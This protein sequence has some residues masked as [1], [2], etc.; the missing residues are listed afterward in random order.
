MQKI[1]VILQWI[2][3]FII[4]AEA[5]IVFLRMK[6]RT[7]YYL[8][9]NCV[10][11]LIHA[12]GYLLRLGA[13]SEE[14]YFQA[15]L[16]EW[17]GRIW[18]MVSLLMFFFRFCE[19]RPP[20]TLSS[21]LGL[22]AVA[23]YSIIITTE[24]TGLFYSGI[25]F[26]K[27]DNGYA[28]Q[29]VRG[30]WYILW[31]IMLILVFSLS[32]AMLFGSL[33]KEKN[34]IRKKQVILVINA[35][36]VLLVLSL[37][38]IVPLR[39]NEYIDLSQFAFS[40]SAIVILIAIVRYSL[41]ETREL[42]REY[43]IDELADG[44]IALD[45]NGEVVYYNHAA[46]LIFPE[47]KEKEKEIVAELKN[48]LETKEPL[49]IDDK[50][51]E[52][53]EKYL[54]KAEV[55]M[56][57]IYS[58][59]DSTEFYQHMSQLEEQKEL[60]DLANQAKSEFL[61]KMSHE[62]R[63]PI[64]AVLGMDEMIL[65]ETND[66]QVRNYA[67]D[68]RTAGRTPLTIINDILDFSKIET[69]KIEIDPEEYDVSSMIYD[70]SNMT[71]VRAKA[72]HL[73]F[74]LSV[75]P[76]VPSKLFGDDVRIRQVLTNILSNAVKY[77]KEG[78]IDF[79]VLL[80]QGPDDDD[81][82]VLTFE[83]EDTGI[84][85]K[86]EDI[87]KLFIEFERI[88][89]IKNT[90]VQGTGLG[91]AITSRMLT[92]MDTNLQIKSEYGKG[93]VFSFD[94]TQK[95][96]D[97]SPIGDFDERIR[98]HLKLGTQYVSS[99]KAPDAR[100]LVVDDNGINL[101]VFASLLKETKIR[102]TEAMSGP[103]AVDLARTLHFDLI[104]MD[105]MMPG[106][107]GI[108]AM[109][110]IRK[111]KDGP[112]ADTPI[113]VLTANA[114]VGSKEMYLKEGFDNFISKPIVSA[115]LED[116]I[117]KYLPQDKMIIRRE[118]P[119]EELIPEK[120]AAKE[121]KNEL[122]PIFGVDWQ[123]ALMR[124]NDPGILMAVVR[125]F[126]ETID[127]QAD[128]LQILKDKLPDTVDD[129]RILVHGMKSAAATAGI[130]T[131]AGMAAVLENAASEKNLDEIDGLHDIFLSE[132]RNYKNRLSEVTGTDE[133]AGDHKEEI[134]PQAL[135]AL[136][137]MLTAAMDDLDIDGADEVINK[138]SA[139]QLPEKAASEFSRLKSAVTQLDA[140]MVADILA[141]MRAE[142]V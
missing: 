103:D 81:N 71:I 139:Y 6:G 110:E 69:G 126:I 109:K 77:T 72:K 58:I 127:I 88:D 74:H 33:R 132:W 12:L 98:Q 13:G 82:V 56:G 130:F 17:G 29:A 118:L 61:A 93:S 140:E 64:N 95:V 15:L 121:E 18:I 43:I 101:K 120:P 54:Q 86:P 91:M 46:L 7:H 52:V 100:V 37:L 68:I 112:N 73:A 76:E 89:T 90:S 131:L 80:G 119:D 53:K 136:Y 63:T 108:T 57:K 44:A 20:K 8:Y 122:P 19:V 92:M 133:G 99:F 32:Y 75:Q 60:A 138:L 107:D 34:A 38:A 111:I 40:G 27:R 128:K 11:M 59:V 83:V 97:D 48:S 42:A 62:I 21:F 23:T 114:V 78:S 96:M 134:S 141:N 25:S 41:F 2:N 45:K 123:M 135:E 49:R 104:F 3:I 85:I 79:R 115:E 9:M 65:R 87:N 5:W 4:L 113:L 24:K 70:L 67:T 22:F 106:M 16:I 28:L 124:L 84:G 66:P 39:I 36:N 51:Y 14:A 55:E 102:I 105:H 117:R 50:I 1:A 129:Y 116:M 30:P 125:E 137:D 31:D 35:L 10:A 47:I 26:I 142:T 94:L